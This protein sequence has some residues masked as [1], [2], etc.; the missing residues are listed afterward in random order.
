MVVPLEKIMPKSICQN[1]EYGNFLGPPPYALR[2]TSLCLT[3]K[4]GI[5]L[6]HEQ[7]H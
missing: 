6:S 3:Q 5:E 2:E 7:Q 1:F 4:Q